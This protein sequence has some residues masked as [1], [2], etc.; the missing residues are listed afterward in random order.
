[1]RAPAAR[2]DAFNAPN[3]PDDVVIVGVDPGLRNTGYGVLHC[4][5]TTTEVLDFSVIKTDARAPVEAR[6]QA[7]HWGIR[8]VLLRW[9]AAELAI[10]MQFI[11]VNARSAF[12][13]G[14]ARAAALLAAAE[15][16]VPV[17]QYTPAEV[18]LTVGGYGRSDKQ[19]MQKNIRMQL[20]MVEAPSPDAADALAIALC[21][22]ASRRMRRLAAGL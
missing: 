4:S 21:H 3:G 6:L 13:I 10:E 2:P 5:P 11:A 9:E 12:A 15:E 7:V 22:Y 8:E 1:M 19:Q 14:E 20:G 18:K 16:R 17:F